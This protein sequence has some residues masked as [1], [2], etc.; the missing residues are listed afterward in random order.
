[1]DIFTHVYTQICA[2]IRNQLSA[3]NI[4]TRLI[5]LCLFILSIGKIVNAIEDLEMTTR[6]RHFA[7]GTHLYYILLQTR[8]RK[9]FFFPSKKKNTNIIWGKNYSKF[10]DDLIQL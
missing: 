10:N 5:S 7:D 8:S 4:F 1:M 6:P 2:H 9:S 3:L